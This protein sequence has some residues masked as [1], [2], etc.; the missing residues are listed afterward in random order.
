MVEL[1]VEP[2]LE[3]V[4]PKP[5]VLERGLGCGEKC[6]ADIVIRILLITLAVVGGNN[7]FED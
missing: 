1:T 2:E 3:M 7:M 6:L 4:E 5:N